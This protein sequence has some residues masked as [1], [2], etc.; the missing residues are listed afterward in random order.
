MSG[1]ASATLRWSR[2]ALVAVVA[3][4]A[5]VVAHVSADGLLPGPAGLLVLF[6]ATTMGAAAFL[7]REIGRVRMVALLV[8]GQSAVHTGLAAMAGHRGD[9]P[10]V[11]TPH[12]VV[13]PPTPVSRSGSYFDQWAASVPHGADHGP[14]VPTWLVHSIADLLAHPAMALGHVLAAAALGL[15]LAYG[16]RAV[17]ALIRL[18]GST[19]VS[20]VRALRSRLLTGQRIGPMHLCLVNVASVPL[21]DPPLECLW[22]RGPIRRGPP[23][24]LLAS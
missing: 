19:A 14:G 21:V 3:L 13:A 18:G 8:G 11:A 22:A 10:R 24:G 20:L 5:G 9:V 16:E 23:A 12:V 2:A 4:G 1:R 17:W 6:A 15:W 7:G